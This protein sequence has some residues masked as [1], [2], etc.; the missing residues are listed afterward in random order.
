MIIHIVKLARKAL[1]KY[2][3]YTA[4]NAFGLIFGMLSALIIAKYIGGTMQFDS[5][6]FN[7]DRIFSITQEESIEGNQQQ[8][9]NST[10]WGVGDYVSQFPDVIDWTR[11]SQQVESLVISEDESGNRK[12]FNENKSFVV[13][14]G[15]FRILTFPML[16]GNPKTALSRINSIVLTKST[17]ER[18]FGSSNPLGK[19]LTARLP[20]GEENTYEITGVIQDVPVKSRFDF[21]ILMTRPRLNPEELWTSPDY[22]IYVLLNNRANYFELADKVTKSLTKVEDLSA[23][24]RKVTIKLEPLTDVKLSKTESLLLAVGVLIV[25][26]SWINYLNQIIAQSYWRIKEIGMLRIMGASKTNLRTQFLVESSTTCLFAF[27]VIVVIYLSLEPFLQ[28]F[29]H[30]HLL[31]LIGDPT[32][33][34]VIFIAVFF[35]GI[36][37]TAAVP[38]A[39]FFSRGFA[40]TLRARFVNGI[41]NLGTRWAL[42]IFQFS[43]STILV[44][45]MLVI[46]RQLEYMDRKDKGFDMSDMLIIKAPMVRDTTWLVK[47]KT[48]ESFK[49]KC[50]SLPYVIA[51]TSSTTVPSDEYRHET[52]LNLEG[53]SNKALIHQSGVDDHFLTMYGVKFIAGHD[54][55]PNARS[56]NKTS[57]ILNESAA[58][59]LGISDYSAMIDSKIIDQQEPSQQYD[60]IGIVKD[61]HQTSMKYEIKPMSFKFN[62]F[63]G[64]F[65]LRINGTK[66]TD[67]NFDR[68]FSE[69]KEIWQQT[70]GD[71]SFNYYFLEQKYKDQD[72]EDFYF[73]RL[74]EFF[75]VLSIAIACL[76][77]FGLT[78][79]LSSKK[80][81]EIGIR[82][83]FGASS[84]SILTTLLRG[85]LGP[86]LLSVIIGAPLSYYLME[87]WLDSYAYKIQIGPGL[88]LNAILVLIGIFLLTVSYQ[89][90]KLARTNPAEILRE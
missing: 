79:L 61:F 80:Q 54:F 12:S 56:K 21:N 32:S 17:S 84:L 4:I 36:A 9:R 5:F 70:Y 31:P 73:G 10:Y 20:W 41:G 33:I 77:L 2:K 34:N 8:S 65:S 35:V 46:T 85:Y 30:S 44:I 64:Q 14:S 55:L 29:T 39:I 6:H 22:P 48:V 57:I 11:Y 63:H 69:I 40:S 62:V 83:T 60:L 71:A 81:R 50:T 68:K 76:G 18:Y 86:L 59:L 26:I 38:T 66:L 47:R 28:A 7:K 74:F 90:I 53:G 89:S 15:F 58:K 52:Y 43:I 25:I 78:I 16:Y 51:V 67:P 23:S 88:M 75:T 42:V 13:D 27:L 19:V 49:D 1:F 45:G 82:K 87:A 72:Q 37:V 3:Y 24:M